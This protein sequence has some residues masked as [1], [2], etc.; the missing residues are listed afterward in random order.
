M[1]QY[2]LTTV[3]NPHSPFDNFEAWY[4]FD[5]NHE[6][7]TLSLL[8]R[9][10]VYS[11]ELSDADQE[12]AIDQAMDEIVRENVSGMHKKVTKEDFVSSS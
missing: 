4:V 9:V 2:L 6:Y 7:G 3:D 1:T 5:T 11:T 10:A 8:A 12:L